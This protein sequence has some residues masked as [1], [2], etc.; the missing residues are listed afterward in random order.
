M[1]KH[2]TKKNSKFTF[3]QETAEVS[4]R[5]INDLQQYVKKKNSFETFHLSTFF[6]KSEFFVISKIETTSEF[7]YFFH[8]FFL[9]TFK[10]TKKFSLFIFSI[11]IKSFE[12]RKTKSISTKQFIVYSKFSNSKK[13]SIQIS[14][15]K[16]NRLIVKKFIFA[17][18]T[19]QKF[20]LFFQIFSICE[21]IKIFLM[22]FFF[23]YK[24]FRISQF[25]FHFFF[26]S[27]IKFILSNRFFLFCIF[28]TIDFRFHYFLFIRANNLEIQ[29]DFFAVNNFL[30]S[31]TSKIVKFI[32][33]NL[34]S[35]RQYQKNQRQ[36][37]INN[38]KSKKFLKLFKFRGTF[39]QKSIFSFI[40]NFRVQKLKNS[41]NS[42]LTISFFDFFHSSR[43][44]WS[45]QLSYFT[46]RSD[47]S[48]SEEDSEKK[49]K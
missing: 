10:I 3:F 26:F 32:E 18:L 47:S 22:Q 28:L 12:S 49:N 23:F 39:Q 40:S 44:F 15:K 11:K 37:K 6:V 33:Q 42:I 25:K 20:V 27:S 35:Q 13:S 21:K 17:S 45:F 46:K 31:N 1:L 14:S 8:K 9:K 30:F 24:S 5:F 16:N 29:T 4:F 41:Q 36:K 2:V 34:L 48:E 43:S 7:D 38:W 19:L